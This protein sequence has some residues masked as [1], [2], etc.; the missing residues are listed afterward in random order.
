MTPQLR[1]CWTKQTSHRP[2]NWHNDSVSCQHFHKF[3]IIECPVTVFIRLRDHLLHLRLGQLITCTHHDQSC[4][5]LTRS[6]Y[7]C[8]YTKHCRYH[9]LPMWVMRCLKFF[10]LMVPVPYLSRTLKAI[11]I[12]SASLTVFILSDIMLQ[13]SGN[14]IMPEP[15]VSYWTINM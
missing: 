6:R 4:T 14:S 5:Q 9:Q 11:L 8:Y 12:M 1:H 2:Q 15:S 13:N 7:N 3:F 10:E